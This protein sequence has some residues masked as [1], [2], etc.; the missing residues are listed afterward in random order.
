MSTPAIVIKTITA[1]KDKTVDDR[2]P[3]IASDSI[4]QESIKVVPCEVRRESKEIVYDILGGVLKEPKIKRAE[5]I[6]NGNLS[7]INRIYLP[8][9]ASFILFHRASS[10]FQI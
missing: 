7:R 2:V 8:I 5:R 6:L 4:S 3:I 1:S 9:K 10:K